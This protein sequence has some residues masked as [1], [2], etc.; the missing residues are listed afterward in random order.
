MAYI[1]NRSPLAVGRPLKMPPYQ[2]ATPSIVRWATVGFC[3]ASKA[4]V[5]LATGAEGLGMG[6]SACTD[7]VVKIATTAVST[8]DEAPPSIHI[9]SEEAELV[10]LEFRRRTIW[11]FY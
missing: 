3:G 4:G 6:A 11:L 8:S 2:E 10:L 1:L 5:A 9:R 7:R